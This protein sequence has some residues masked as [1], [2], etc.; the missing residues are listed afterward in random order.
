MLTWIMFG[1]LLGLQH[2]LEADHVAAVASI[3]ADKKGLG[4]MA[5]HGAAWGVG[6]ALALGAFGGAVYALKLSMDEQLAIGLEGGVGVM[7]VLLGA[8]ALYRVRQER[9]H[10]HVHSHGEQAHFHA[11][12]HL[13][14]VADHRLSRH[15][16][17]HK[18]GSWM[19]S[20]S[21]GLMHGLAGSAAL[22]ALT[23][24][25]APSAGLGFAFMVL[26]GLGS[27]IGMAAFSAVIAVPLSYTAA[28]LTWANR[29]LQVLAGV[30]AL[31]IGLR[32]TVESAMALS[33]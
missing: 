5:R 6:H 23:V 18:R 21:V 25:T 24:S 27:I 28:T 2:A 3:A 10:F 1:F 22:V 31:G 20:L 14:D 15:A 12:S 33:Q 26:F 7:L 8:R 30:I 13:G 16:H 29:G 19:R 32:I 9:I 11:H 17:L 4:R